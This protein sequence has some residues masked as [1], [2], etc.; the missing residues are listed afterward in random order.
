V[1][2]SYCTD[3]ERGLLESFG[4]M[5][6]MRHT[7]GLAWL[8]H[9]MI[10]MRVRVNTSSAVEPACLTSNEIWFV[11]VQ[12]ARSGDSDPMVASAV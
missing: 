2:C 5:T 1:T 6:C 11:S 7:D 4:S 3:A 8:N 9:R 12:A 10:S